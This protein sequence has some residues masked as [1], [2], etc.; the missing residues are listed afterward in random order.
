MKRTIKLTLLICILLL[1]SALVLTACKKDNP[2][3]DKTQQ[4]S[5]VHT[6]VIAPAVVPTCTEAGLTEG[7]SCSA[8]NE[9][10]LAQTV[11][12][13]LGHTE[14]IDV[15]VAPTCTETGLTEGKHC[16]VC[17]EIITAQT[18]LDTLG[19]HDYIDRTCTKCGDKLGSSGLEYLPNGDYYTVSGIG[20]CTDTY[21]IIP[22]TYNGKPVKSISNGAFR[23][24]YTIERVYVPGSITEI[25]DFA[26]EYCTGLTSATVENGVTRIGNY[27]FRGCTMLAS[28]TIPNS[29]TSIRDR[30]FYG[31]ESLDNVIIPYGVTSIAR[32]AFSGCTGLTSITISASVTYIGERAFQTCQSLISINLQGDKSQWDAIE[33]DE[34]WNEYTGDYIVYCTDGTISK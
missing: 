31:C 27:A 10:I 5:H 18:I 8:C 11:V 3:E 17:N 20:A 23:E 4:P 6:E 34:Y 29:V 14:V 15:S 19:G 30:A 24:C 2:M 33:K 21:V 32:Y 22:S 9:V 28:I 12:E 13:A 1:A 7:K 25:S 26:F 16:S